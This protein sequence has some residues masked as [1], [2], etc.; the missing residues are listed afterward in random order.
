[1]TEIKSPENQ[2]ELFA[3]FSQEPRR[4]QRFPS[5]AKSHNPILIS[6][7]LEQILLV[8]IVLVL[9]LCLAF[10]WGC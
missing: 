5:L 8:G 2:Q 4:L 6:T 1:M 10:F 9:T 7:T 3:E